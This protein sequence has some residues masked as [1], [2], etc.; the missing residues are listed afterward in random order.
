MKKNKKVILTDVDGVL[1]DFTTSLLKECGS[2]IKSEDINNWDCFSM[3]EQEHRDYALNKVLKDPDFW[4]NLPLLPHAQTAVEDMRRQGTLLF[5]TSPWA[6]RTSGWE[7]KGW[8]WAR[9]HWL[10]E[11]FDAS[12]EELII[13]YSKH[14]IRG[15]ILIDDRL[16]NVTTW[17]EHNLRGTA[18]LM[19]QPHNR[20]DKWDNEVI[21]TEHGWEFSQNLNKDTKDWGYP[22]FV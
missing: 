10:R 5:V 16:K 15:D 12:H 21:I 3:M 20:Y 17:A 4:R 11:H 18:Y 14:Y 2:S 1:A 9:A 13:A 6:N 8:G 7:C 19:R 22:L